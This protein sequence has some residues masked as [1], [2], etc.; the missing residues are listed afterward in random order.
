[1]DFS[2][3]SG[4][5][6][7]C[8]VR[9]GT[10]GALVADESPPQRARGRRLLELGVRSRESGVGSR[11]LGAGHTELIRALMLRL[12]ECPPEAGSWEVGVGSWECG[13]A[14]V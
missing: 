3:A 1:M 2:G 6:A 13:G 7:S 5:R 14:V 8:A 9:G 12:L 11:E 4:N 10:P